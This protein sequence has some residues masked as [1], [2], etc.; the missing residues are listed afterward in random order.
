MHVRLKITLAS[1]HTNFSFNFKS[2]YST[3]TYIILMKH[4]ELDIFFVDIK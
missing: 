2:K 1:V 3:A 4:C